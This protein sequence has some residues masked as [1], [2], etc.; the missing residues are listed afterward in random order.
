LRLWRLKAGAAINGL[1]TFSFHN[2][3]KIGWRVA[4]NMFYKYD[5]VAVKQLLLFFALVIV[6]FFGIINENPQGKLPLNEEKEL[7]S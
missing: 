7:L 4:L 6:V 1:I 2:S 3:A 5:C